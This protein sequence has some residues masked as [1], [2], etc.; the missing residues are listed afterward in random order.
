M[1]HDENP[2]AS[3]GRDNGPVL[4]LSLFL[5]LLAFFILL[6]ALS[7]IETRKSRAV[8]ESLSSTFRTDKQ[9]NLKSERLVSLL[10]DVPNPEEVQQE[11]ERLWSTAIPL[12]KVEDV[13]KGSTM[14]L[15]FPATDLFLGGEATL[16]G[17]RADLIS[18]TASVL[19]AKMDGYIASM[20]VV[21]EVPDATSVRT[22]G[23]LRKGGD[24]IPDVADLNDPA[25]PL[26]QSGALET[27]GLPFARMSG[28]AK[29]LVKA[30]APPDTFEVGFK[31]GDRDNIRIRFY[32]R[33]VGEAFVTFSDLARPAESR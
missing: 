3:Q 30:G 33:P 20:E 11:M 15:V 1:E 24:K 14:Q 8:I 27:G 5:L 9:S 31:N 28:L 19:A 17:D 13:T 6:N 32:I 4:F 23:P 10:G 7:T 21:A 18:A 22:E 29:A 2:A 16:R 26:V 12:A 25:R